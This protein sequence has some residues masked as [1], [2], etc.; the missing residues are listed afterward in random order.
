MSRKISSSCLF[1]AIT[2]PLALVLL[3]PFSSHA[4]DPEEGFVSLVDGK[5]L[6]GWIGALDAYRVEDGKLVCLE[7]TAG[8]LLTEGEY[9]DFLFRFEFR[10]SPG[11]NN[12]L[13]VRCPPS[14]K[15][16]LH[17]EGIELQIL[18]DSAEKY[19]TLQPYQY[20]GSVYGIQP[21]RRGH[22]KPVGEW[23][24][25]DVTVHGRRIKVVLNGETIVDVD[26]DEATKNGTMDGQPHP[27]LAR[28]TG[29]LG[30]LGHGD[31]IEFRNLRIRE[32]T[33]TAR[34]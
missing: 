1:V 26:L 15:G 10:L 31:R 11:A 3:N 17:L 22:L 33:S 16:N 30:F 5:S 6:A 25:Q 7:G 21:A 8:N 27:G 2:A 24:S 9:R 28:E 18:D 32:I 19:Q 14:A 13:G 20:H 29:H 34:R 12:G 23:N 4:A